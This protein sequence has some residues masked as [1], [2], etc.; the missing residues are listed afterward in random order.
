MKV[1]VGW[2]VKARCDYDSH[3]GSTSTNKET[4]RSW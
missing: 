2:N 3:Q 1:Y 4:N